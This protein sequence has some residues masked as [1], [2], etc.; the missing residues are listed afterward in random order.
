[1]KT[2]PFAFQRMVERKDPVAW[3]STSLN[4]NEADDEMEVNGIENESLDNVKRRRM[5]IFRWTGG[6]DMKNKDVTEAVNLRTFI[7]EI[8]RELRTAPRIQV[9]VAQPRYCEAPE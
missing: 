2:N 1:M 8:Q 3:L 9:R 5:S 7:E 6:Y 4:I